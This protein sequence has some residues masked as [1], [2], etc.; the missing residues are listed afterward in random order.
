MFQEGSALLE[1]FIS[2]M[3]ERHQAVKVVHHWPTRTLCLVVL[4]LQ[5]LSINWYLMDNL[6]HTWAAIYVAD[7]ITLLLFVAAFYFA[8]ENINKEKHT[9]QLTV[10]D[11]SHQPFTYLPWLVY[12][13]VLDVKIAVIFST[14]STDLDENSFFG[15]NTLK[16]SIALSGLVFLLFLPTQHDVKHG[17]RKDLITALTSTIIFDVLDGVDFLDNLFEK[18]V[19]ETFPPE[20][21]DVI[22]VLFCINALLPTVPLFTLAKTKFGLKELPEKLEMLHKFSIAYLINLPLF[23]TRMVTWHGLSQGISIFLL[24]NVIAMG[25]VTFEVLEHFLCMRPEHSGPNPDESHSKPLAQEES[26]PEG[27]TDGFIANT[28]L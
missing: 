13:I 6:S 22:I 24:K 15:P 20:L 26:G 23:V 21:D 8:T 25:V 11:V 14:F 1:L 10:S 12:A 5:Y 17:H 19:R 18:E 9:E 7:I 2:T 27:P 28:A 3:V 16:S 4:I